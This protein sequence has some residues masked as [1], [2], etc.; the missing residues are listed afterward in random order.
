MEAF[1]LEYTSG[2][3][4]IREQIIEYTAAETATFTL[5]SLR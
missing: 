4:H 3:I 5:I 1:W 2:I